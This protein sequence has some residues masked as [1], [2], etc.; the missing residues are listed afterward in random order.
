MDSGFGN[1]VG[2]E[3]VAEID[4]VDIVA[5]ANI[6]SDTEA[7]DAEDAVVYRCLKPHNAKWGINSPFQIAVHD[8][9]ENLKEEIDGIYQHRQEV[10]PR[11][12]GHFVGL[13][14]A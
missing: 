1:D 11:F 3:T 14:A 5:G 13:C 9:E 7:E 6:S 8:S 10:Q 2:V 4:G 12:T